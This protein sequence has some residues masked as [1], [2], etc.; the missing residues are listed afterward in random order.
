MEIPVISGFLTIP[1]SGGFS[2]KQISKKVGRY[3]TGK[4]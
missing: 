4:C 3:N 2:I 1:Q